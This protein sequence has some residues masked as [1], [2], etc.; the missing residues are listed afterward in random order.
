MNA[1]LMKAPLL[2]FAALALSLGQAYACP[3]AVDFIQK[4]TDGPT[5]HVLGVAG[6]GA[7]QLDSAVRSALGVRVVG[8]SASEVGAF[9]FVVQGGNPNVTFKSFGNDGCALAEGT[10]HL[11]TIT[12]LT[13]SLGLD[14]VEIDARGNVTLP[15]IYPISG[16]DWEYV[17]SI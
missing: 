10:L 17:V 1:P 16:Q 7:G 9:L 3:T 14:L 12:D 8:W 5:V 6:D 13:M 2:S 15:S 11:T 4:S